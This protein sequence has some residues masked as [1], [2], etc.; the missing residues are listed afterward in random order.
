MDKII[1]KKY[2]TIIVS[3]VVLLTTII[4]MSAPAFAA[5]VDGNSDIK[6]ACKGAVVMDARNGNILYA[7]NSTRRFYPASC[8]KLMTA[9]VALE[10]CNDLSK[11]LTVSDAAVNG[12]DPESSHIALQVGEKITMEQALYGLLLAS[13]NDAAVAIAEGV[14]GSQKDFAKLMNKKAQE[15]GLTGSHFADPHGLY[16]PDHYTTPQDLAKIMRACLQN[17]TFVKI[18]TTI[19]YTIPRTNKSK[20]RVLWN[21]H[22][23]VKYKYYHHPAVIGGKSGYV[24][25][26]GFN[27]VTVGE[28]N[29][30]DLIIVTMRGI[31]AVDMVKDTRKLLDYYLNNYKSVTIKSDIRTIDLPGRRDVPVRSDGATFDVIV[32]KAA[33]KSDVKITAAPKKNIRFPVKR[34]EQV[35]TVTASYGGRTAGTAPLYATRTVYSGLALVLHIGALVLIGL[36]IFFII[37]GLVRIHKRKTKH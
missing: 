20:K 21:N 9:L 33:S 29:N 5:E 35:G 37:A 31:T 4:C 24:T 17:P 25:K 7:K 11:T 23:M 10:N 3:F 6:V 16:K 32:P 30:M 8:T 15:L 27:L 1:K 34:G 2:L 14:A 36:V 28:M 19:K 18:F 26:S 13:G 22:R 12:I